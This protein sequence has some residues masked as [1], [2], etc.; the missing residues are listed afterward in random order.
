MARWLNV[1]RGELLFYSEEPWIAVTSIFL[2]G[3]PGV[4][5]YAIL[6]AFVMVFGSARRSM[7][8]GGGERF[9]PYLLWA[10]LAIFV[11][12]IVSVFFERQGWW[13]SFRF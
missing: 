13:A 10:P 11:I 3:Y 12:L 5:F 2:V 1:R 7:R 6:M 8:R 4:I 9:S